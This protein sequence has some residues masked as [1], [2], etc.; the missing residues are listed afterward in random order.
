M[1][2]AG[3]LCTM[4]CDLSFGDALMVSVAYA[5]NIAAILTE[6]MHHGQ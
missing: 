2:R 4:A 5:K 1:G 3:W 6:D